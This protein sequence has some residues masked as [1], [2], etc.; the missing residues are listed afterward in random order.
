MGRHLSLGLLCAAALLTAACGAKAQVAMP[1]TA[2]LTVP[3]APARVVVP[4]APEAPRT[5]PADPAPASSTTPTTQN[6][7]SRPRP[8]TPPS[9]PATPP[10]APPAATAPTT[11]APA[12]PTPLEATPN[13]S[14]FERKARDL[15][16]T[17]NALLEKIDYKGLSDGG[18]VQFDTAKRFLQQADAALKVKNLVYAWQ[19][20]DKAN[21]IATLLK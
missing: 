14:E 5:P 12:A 2:P 20:A 17:A 18:R 4:A 8:E 21:T 9:R 3:P 16:S 6:P 11:P 7:A 13:P 15:V 10:A 1:D 19:L